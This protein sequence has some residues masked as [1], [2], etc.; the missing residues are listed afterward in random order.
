[1][2]LN[3]IQQYKQIL[4]ELN[5]FIE[6]Y[7]PFLTKLL[8]ELQIVELEE[9]HNEVSNYP[10]DTTDVIRQFISLTDKIKEKEFQLGWTLVQIRFTCVM[11]EGR[12]PGSNILKEPVNKLEKMIQGLTKEDIAN[13]LKSLK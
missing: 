11:I 4:E 12:R 13:L 9:K 7:Q 6:K 3:L 5:N 1:M 10:S 2:R 8:E